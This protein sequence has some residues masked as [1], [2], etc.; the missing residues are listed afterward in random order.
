[1]DI[2]ESFTDFDRTVNVIFIRK[3]WYGKFIDE[4]HNLIDYAIFEPILLF[5][6]N[7]AVNFFQFNI[8]CPV[9]LYLSCL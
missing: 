7:W 3:R 9:L 1:M 5:A 4:E 8:I 2:A 6:I